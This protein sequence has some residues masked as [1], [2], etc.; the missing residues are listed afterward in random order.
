MMIPLATAV[1]DASKRPS[2]QSLSQSELMKM[3]VEQK[4]KIIKSVTMKEGPRPRQ[5]ALVASIWMIST[6]F[7]FERTLALQMQEKGSLVREYLVRPW[8]NSSREI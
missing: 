3:T 4:R 2:H 1:L 8:Q 7:G 6:F 5:V